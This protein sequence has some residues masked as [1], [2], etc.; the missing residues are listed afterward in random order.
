MLT[1][2]A[3][4]LGNTQVIHGSDSHTENSLKRLLLLVRV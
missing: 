4:E 1:K 2:Q 3:G